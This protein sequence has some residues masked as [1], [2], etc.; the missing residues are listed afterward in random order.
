MNEKE[1]GRKEKSAARD[2]V[3]TATIRLRESKLLGR[4]TNS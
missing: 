3:D 4:A 2:L 1:M